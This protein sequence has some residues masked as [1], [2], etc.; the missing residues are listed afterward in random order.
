[1]GNGKEHIPSPGRGD[2]LQTKLIK[3]KPR[4]K[5]HAVSF[6]KLDILLLERHLPMMLF[7]MVNVIHDRFQIRR[8]E[9]TPPRAKSVRVSRAPMTAKAP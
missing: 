1:M 5:F 9:I 3:N 8:A 4:I 6:Q 2:R 7:L